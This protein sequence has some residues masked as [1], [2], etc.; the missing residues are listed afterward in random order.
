MVITGASSGIGQATAEAFARKGARLVLV[1]RN[2]EAIE[3]VAQDC[4]DLGA[5]AMAIAADVTDAMAIA[6]VAQQA[7][8]FGGGIDVWVSNVGT[9]AVGAF[10]EVPIEAHE[11]VVRASLI[12]HMNDAHAV[13]PVFLRQRRGVFINMISLGGFAAAPFA[14]AYSASKFGLRGFAEALR[15]ELIHEPGIHVCDI[16]PSFVDTP[17]ISHGANYTGRELSAPPPVLDARRVADAIVDLAARPRPTTMVGAPTAL[18][19]LA[20]AVSPELTTRGMA[21]FLEAYFRRAPR[22]GV[23]SGNLFRSPPQPGGIDGGLRAPRQRSGLAGV[24]L[25]VAAVGILAVALRG[26]RR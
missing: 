5:K 23:S 1:A 13:L 25:G 12:G 24:A 17:G 2:A 15:G 22:T 21:L 3:A 7:A 19:R 16:Y 9:G 10:H 14:A 20:H 26:R 18:V 8:D 11:Q 4:R 6:E